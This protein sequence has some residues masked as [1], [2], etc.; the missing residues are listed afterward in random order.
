VQCRLIYFV[1][2]LT[3]VV[4]VAH[5]PFLCLRAWCVCVFVCL[6]ASRLP[7]DREERSGDTRIKTAG[8]VL[9]ESMEKQILPP[10]PVEVKKKVS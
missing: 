9:R 2:V 10:Q 6:C 5:M 3:S 8:W 4:H 7:G 1:F